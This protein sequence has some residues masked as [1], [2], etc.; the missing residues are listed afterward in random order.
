MSFGEVGTTTESLTGGYA[1][2]ARSVGHFKDTKILERMALI[3]EQSWTTTSTGQLYVVDV[4]NALSTVSRN[5]V[6]LN[7]FEYLRCGVELTVRLN[8]NQFYYGALMATLWPS[9]GTGYRVDERAVLDPTLISASSAESVIKTWKYGFPNAWMQCTGLATSAY[10]VYFSLD[11][12]APLIAAGANMPSAVTVQIWARFIDVELAYPVDT[13]GALNR[14]ATRIYAQSSE[15]PLIVKQPAKRSTSHPSE[16]ENTV[17]KAMDAISSVTI[18]DAV[19]EVS[20]LAS[21]VVNSWGPSLGFLFD[22]PDRQ[23]PQ[24]P[25]IV[26]GSIDFFNTDI[27]DSNVSLSVY[28]G[29]Y[30]D[31]GKSRMPM[32]KNFTVSDYARIPGLRDQAAVFSAQ[33]QSMSWFCIRSHPTSSTYKIP[34]DYAYLSSRMWRGSIKVTLFFF[35][36]SFISARF[37][38]QYINGGEFPSSFPSEYDSGLSRVINVKGDTIDSFTLPWLS[39]W[40]WTTNMD[41][42][43]RVVCTSAIANTDTAASPIIYCV[44]FVA[45]GDDIQFAFPRVPHESEWSGG[46]LTRR[47]AKK[48]RVSAKGSKNIQAQSAVGSIFG[49]TFP[50][51]GEDAGYDIDRGF[52]TAEQLG[53]ITDLCKR[54]SMMPNIPSSGT[55][56]LYPIAGWDFSVLDAQYNSLPTSETT[57]FVTWYNFRHTIFGAWRAAFLYRSGGYKYRYYG[58]PSIPM[59]WNL[60]GSS[61]TTLIPGTSYR[62]PYDGIVRL[63]VP[64]VSNY[65]FAM[66][67]SA[68]ANLTPIGISLSPAGSINITAVNPQFIAARDDVQFGYPILPSGLIAP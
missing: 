39:S 9:G 62:S 56:P 13:S 55:T 10:P 2:K 52:A 46:P 3:S 16:E 31:P 65:P 4:L 42:Q 68:D 1:S 37:V 34:L 49:Q 7:Q 59:V 30:V 24:T 64:Q 27:P 43:F 45:G 18:G 12:I 8:T 32:T 60:Y 47:E 41:P 26:E 35:T 20:S 61:D 50:P 54:Y 38:V 21:Y 6:I 5:Q 22:K 53:P 66:L 57:A 19:E 23:E 33:N 44:P 51:I 11:V 15:G 25:V 28:K 48:G 17:T 14:D 58:D 67:D 40:W 63:T 29:K 36:S